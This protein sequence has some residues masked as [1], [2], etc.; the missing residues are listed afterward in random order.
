MNNTDPEIVSAENTRLNEKE[1]QD[2]KIY[3]ESYPQAVFIQID[4]PCNH[5]CLFCSRPEAYKYFDLDEFNSKFEE[6]L[7]PVFQRVNRINLTGSG[8]HLFL[9]EAKRNLEY[10]NQFKQAEK[11]FAT[12]GSSLTPKMIDYIAESDN[13]YVIHLSLHA[14]E[15]ELHKSITKADNFCVIIDN[16]LYLRKVRENGANNIQLNIVFV[17]TTKNIEHLGEFVNFAGSF[18]PDAVIAYYNFI[19]RLD[20]KMLSCYFAQSQTARMLNTA[21]EESLLWPESIRDNCRLELPPAFLQ[22]EYP[23]YD[24]CKEVWSQIMINSEGAIIPCDASGDSHENVI[25]SADFMDVWN[26]K[27]YTNLRKQLAEKKND[28]ARYCFRANPAA[29]NDFRSHFITRGRTKKEI[30]EFLKG[31]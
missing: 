25:G 12:N 27:Y 6:L 31:T 8:E 7:F 11:M 22:K 5:D 1:Y 13:K 4:G 15:K 20:Q 19:Y 28:C 30:A 26:G 10:F 17:A 29:V 14:G 24:L 18:N 2:K 21:K 3:L 23:V 9:P 16:L